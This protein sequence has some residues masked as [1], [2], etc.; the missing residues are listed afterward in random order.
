MEDGRGGGREPSAHCDRHAANIRSSC[1]D[2]GG[3]NHEDYAAEG[4]RGA[5]GDAADDGLSVVARQMRDPRTNRATP[6]HMMLLRLESF[7]RVHV[8]YLSGLRRA[9][10]GH[11]FF[12]FRNKEVSSSGVEGEKRVECRVPGEMRRFG[13]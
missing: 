8:P 4:D 10:C 6:T 13:F 11:G 1:H 2:Q 7:A 9:R 3:Q 12:A 5:G